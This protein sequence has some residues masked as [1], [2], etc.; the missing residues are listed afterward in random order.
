MTIK[1][2]SQLKQA[3]M[4]LGLARECAVVF[5]TPLCVPGVLLKK[6]RVQLSGSFIVSISS[7]QSARGVLC[8]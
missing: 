8:T 7:C 3:A 5:L 2:P 1:V 6:S 4:C